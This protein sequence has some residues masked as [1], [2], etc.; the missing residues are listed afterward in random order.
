MIRLS[1]QNERNNLYEMMLNHLQTGGTTAITSVPNRLHHFSGHI[2]SPIQLSQPF[3]LNLVVLVSEIHKFMQF[4]L[5]S[6]V[7]AF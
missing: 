6:R 1:K 3:A 5:D 2:P 7:H 4:C